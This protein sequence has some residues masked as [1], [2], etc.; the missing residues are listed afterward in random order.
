MKCCLFKILSVYDGISHYV[1]IAIHYKYVHNFIV[2]AFLQ[3]AELTDKV[4]MGISERNKLQQLLCSSQAEAT[5]KVLYKV[6]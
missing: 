3:V 5:A 2:Y 4:S 1:P 6:L